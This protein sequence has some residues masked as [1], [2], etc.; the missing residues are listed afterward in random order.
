M[1]ARNI[2]YMHYVLVQLLQRQ[3]YGNI[4]HS[5]INQKRP[6]YR[7][8]GESLQ[9]PPWM[10]LF[11]DFLKTYVFRTVSD[12][13]FRV[14]SISGNENHKSSDTF[15]YFKFPTLSSFFVVFR[16]VVWLQFEFSKNFPQSWT[17]HLQTFLT[18]SA[19][20]NWNQIII[21]RK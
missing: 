8:F 16:T 20:V 10:L 1:H 18:S 9:M 21:T 2:I 13:C 6:F 14:N 5:Y 7:S 15:F 4:L 3:Y 12:S 17:K 19:Q 11:D